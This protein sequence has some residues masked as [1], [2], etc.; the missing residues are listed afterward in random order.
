V[1]VQQPG[2]VL[3]IRARAACRGCNNGWMNKLE[4]RAKPILMGMREAQRPDS[5]ITLSPDRA[6][7]VAAW[8]GQD[9]MDT[10]GKRARRARMV[11]RVVPCH[12]ASACCFTKLLGA[13]AAHASF[14]RSLTI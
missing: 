6:A 1:Q 9:V 14:V 8:T 3:G 10:R 11:E 7:T 2:T 5:V 12:N 13:W 4:Q